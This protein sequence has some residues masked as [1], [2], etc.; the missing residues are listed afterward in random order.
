MN[1]WGST[2]RSIAKVARRACNEAA[3]ADNGPG[4]RLRLASQRS[5]RT[6]PETPLT[7]S[8]TAVNGPETLANPTNVA[9]RQRFGLAPTIATFASPMRRPFIP[10]AT[11]ATAVQ[12]NQVYL[13]RPTP[14]E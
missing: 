10:H 13:T 2:G 1:T 9:Y 3:K 14:R 4:A 12:S 5:P 7:T 11:T 6:H 8:A